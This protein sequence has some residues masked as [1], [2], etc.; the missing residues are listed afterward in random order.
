MAVS[1]GKPGQD[2]SQV[3]SLSLIASQR[4]LNAS[5]ETLQLT[6]VLKDA[7]GNTLTAADFP[8][9]WR[10]SRPLD[11]GVN[12]E[13]KVTALV[14]SGYSNISLTLTGTTMSVV[15]LVSVASGEGGGSG[16]GQAKEPTE[17]NVNGEIKFQF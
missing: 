12:A 2:L 10:S 1:S 13:G 11:F 4:F 14:G 9:E 6:P 17:E 7:Q 3:K 5:G 16:S 15:Q 8:L